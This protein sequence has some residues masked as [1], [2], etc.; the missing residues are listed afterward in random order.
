[1]K[2]L[3]L[4][5]GCGGM[6]LGFR[7]QGFQVCGVDINEFTPAIFEQNDIGEALLVDLMRELVDMP[8]DVLT[9]GPPCRPW[10]PY[11]QQKGKRR[12]RHPDFPL[13]RRYFEHVSRIRPAVFILENVVAATRDV[14]QAAAALR[15][16]YAIEHR[17]VDYSQW[18]AATRRRRLFVTGVRRELGKD[19]HMLFELLDRRRTH[20]KTVRDAIGS[21]PQGR[22]SEHVF[23]RLRTLSK[24]REYYRT[25][26][27]GW[28]VLKWDEP[29]PSF[30]NVHKT[31]ILHPESTSGAR[32]RVISVREALCIMGF[33]RDF[34]FPVDMPLG[35]RYQMVADAVSPRFA[36]ALAAAVK[37]FLGE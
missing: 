13:L 25:G 10:S 2:V 26:K 20:P 3:D 1:M 7:Q 21:L 37:E 33:P 4:F 19:P 24:Y 8:C 23:P 32:P 35:M 12:D 28:F 36:S 14:L 9:G 29:A 18:G 6:S 27:Y 34:V 5:A 16:E 30:G 22:D 15:E 17:I 31:Y 11:N